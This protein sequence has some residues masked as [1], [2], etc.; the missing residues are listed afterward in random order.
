MTVEVRRCADGAEYERAFMAIGQYFGAA[1][2]GE[3]RDH[4]D[5]L[6]PL[7]RMHAAWVGGELVGG[8]GSFPFRLSVPGGDV[9]CAGTTLIGVAPTHRRRGVLRAMMRTHLDDVHERG[10]PL[11]ALWASEE[12]IY[13]RFGYGRAAFAGE[14]SVP[15]EHGSYAAARELRGRV[16]LVGPDEAVNAFPPLWE[17]FARM[18][19]GVFDRSRSWWEKRVLADPREHRDGAGPKR[20]ALLELDGSPAAYA[21]YRHRV[22]WEAGSSTGS[23][24]VVEAVGGP[25]DALA[26]LWRFLLD[27]DWTAS[28]AAS[29]VPP[30]H[31]LFF[32]LAEPRRMRYRM[33]D[34]LW[35]RLVDAG[36]ALAA[37]TYADGDEIVL[38]LHDDFC[39]W[40][41][42][43]WRVGGEGVERTADAADLSLAAAVL[44]A[45]Y[46]GGIGFTQLAQ[47]GHVEELTPGALARAD[48]LFR[49]GL[50]P[51]CPEIF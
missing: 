27:I 24:E 12:G 36:A 8:A 35:V 33:G 34:G 2:F 46:L 37:R 11:A 48:A 23:V 44:G 22:S 49:H 45:A 4:F 29:L 42:G 38:D 14:V 32:L 40:N 7:E 16:R 41:E 19:P 9:A 21:V 1:D 28:T 6:L 20:L 30:D 39:A 15:K 43:R 18:R 50:H 5:G 31:P 13:G 25:G 3:W 17:A 51:W 10:E 26:E 47:G